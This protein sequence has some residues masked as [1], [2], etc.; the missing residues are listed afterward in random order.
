[1]AKFDRWHRF[2]V[3]RQLDLRGLYI[4]QVDNAA[5]KESIAVPL[6][7]F[8]RLRASIRD[9][10]ADPQTVADRP[11][12]LRFGGQTHFT[13]GRAGA[14][15]DRF[16]I[17][18]YGPDEL[19]SAELNVSREAIPSL[20]GALYNPRL[21]HPNDLLMRI[22]TYHRLFASTFSEATESMTSNLQLRNDLL[23]RVE[24]YQP[25]LARRMPEK[26][27]D[28]L[29]EPAMLK[30]LA[31][32]SRTKSSSGVS[33]RSRLGERDAAQQ[34]QVDYE[35]LFEGESA[36]PRRRRRAAS[37]TSAST[38]KASR[39]ELTDA[40][41]NH[42]SVPLLASQV[43]ALRRVPFRCEL[44]RE[45]VKQ[46]RKNFLDDRDATFYLGFEILDCIFEV[47][48]KL[49]TFRMPLYYL[50]VRIV[51]SGREA[52]LHPTEGDRCYLNH[53][54]LA[55]L[56]EGYSTGDQAPKR[57]SELL[58]SM[59]SHR[60][61]IRGAP[62]RI[63]VLR[64][65]PC[66]EE[67]FERTREILLGLP[68][69]NGKGGLLSDVKVKAIECDLESVELYKAP[70]SSSP[71]IRALND[72]LG[73]ILKKA[74]GL[75]EGFE[76][77]LLARALS[78]RV[79]DTEAEAEFSQTLSMHGAQPP[80]LRNLVERLNDHD[81]VLLEGPPGTGKT[82]NIAN[83]VIHCVAT[84]QR[85]L[86]VSDQR[87]AVEAL[88]EQ[89]QSYVVGKNR[90]SP[91]GRMLEQLWR[92]GIKVLE[93]LPDDMPTLSKWARQVRRMLN[94]DASQELD[95]PSDVP[96]YEQ[97]V[98]RLDQRISSTTQAIGESLRQKFGGVDGLTLPVVAGRSAHPRSEAEVSA[99]LAAARK[100]SEADEVIGGLANHIRHRERLLELGL[101]EIYE[102]FSLEGRPEVSGRRLEDV[103]KWLAALEESSPKEL[104]DFDRVQAPE[105][106]REVQAL[107]RER[108]AEAFPPSSGWTGRAA[109]LVRALSGPHE[110]HRLVEELQEAVIDQLG[111]LA[112]REA[113][114]P[115]VWDSLSRIH[116]GLSPSGREPLDVVLELGIA[117]HPSS[118]AP[119]ESIQ[120]LLETLS[121]LQRERDNLVRRKFMFGLG[122]VG[123]RAFGTAKGAGTPRLTSILA[124]LDRLESAS[125]WARATDAVRELQELLYDVFPIWICR[126]QAVPFLLPCRERSFDLVIVDEATQCRV[127]DAIPLL[128]RG[129]KLMAVGDERQTVLAKNSPI[130]DYLFD[131]FE[132]DEHLRFAQARG[133][134][135]GG[136]HLF[137]LVKRIKQASVMLDEH[138]RC[139]PDIIEFSNRYVYDSQLRT[140]KWKM[141]GSPP[142]VWVDHGET[143]ADS[144]EREKSGKYKGIETKMIDRFYAYVA[145]TLKRIERE[146]GE[147]I[148]PETDV[149]LVYFLLKNEPYV[150]ATKS[151]LLRRLPRGS[152]VLDGAGAALQGKERNY[153]FYLWDITRYNM[154]SFRQGD[155]ETKRK[156]ELNVLMSRPKR[157][158]YHY[159]HRDFD[160]LKH[161]SSSITDFLWRARQK[162]T[163]KA[164]P[165][166]RGSGL[167]IKQL[168]E[169]ALGE[170]F[171]AEDDLQFDVMLGNPI[172]GI[173]V[174]LLPPEG[175]RDHDPS[176]GIIDL[177]SF[178]DAKDPGQAVVDYFFQVQ[179]AIPRVVPVFSFVHELAQP[180]SVP[181][182][183]I[184]AL[185]P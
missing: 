77:S 72:D 117:G 170:S 95:W 20:V 3:F 128:F 121:K 9:A 37:D 65:L 25:A 135:G 63:R 6:E 28:D 62:D 112:A 149:A 67:V 162:S 15:G 154:A 174:M 39:N 150:K 147:E 148:N 158:A 153:I 175:H 16:V 131:D 146:T 100:L 54:G 42:F 18:S 75:A 127:D 137:G 155:D 159:L 104:G 130:D 55:Q 178:M 183:R 102:L 43:K 8:D 97:T 92:M 98:A 85:L 142:S 49:K 94:V 133:M 79:R 172:Y 114:D 34:Y 1:M 123:R 156:G 56:I 105:T 83:L 111:L 108:W 160:T 152:N 169:Q 35:E 176:V 109:R 136:S 84:G 57:L 164:K 50:P 110:L 106:A 11:T 99:A 12:E 17:R 177:A 144:S 88:R 171:T 19:P 141:R 40:P 78:P 46:L 70:E 124:V 82:Y 4:Y 122:T 23:T 119:T 143:R 45:D 101:H 180:N 30:E 89:I 14:D 53:F 134:K 161:S 2:V 107:L 182:T 32:P 103:R 71:V 138:Y 24:R 36:A 157:R 116:S 120:E 86:V 22:V 60:Y 5:N 93:E 165:K 69:E 184:Q 76:S 29:V 74:E 52:I 81:L 173:D 126:K 41:V 47:R 27:K 185:R 10:G 87:A 166:L 167:L 61:V 151:D 140:M 7:L 26:A 163:S 129:R 64:M 91:E 73:Q 115:E 38:A 31:P 113:M 68:G 66:G 21:H 13:V 179:R 44:T 145:R 33:F 96:D 168:L 59:L 90:E 51:E 48:K 118:A 139:P 125:T 80:A 132:L 58:E 181:V